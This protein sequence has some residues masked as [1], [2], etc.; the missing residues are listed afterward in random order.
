MIK[1]GEPEV[2]ELNTN[3]TKDVIKLNIE[4]K[5]DSNPF[6]NSSLKSKPTNSGGGLELLMNTKKQSS[7]NNNVDLKDLQELENDLNDLTNTK[8]NGK[9][10]NVSFGDSTKL[11]FDDLN[12]KSEPSIKIDNIGNEVNKLLAGDQIGRVVIQHGE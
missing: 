2:I 8:T 5:S 9:P 1:I 11:K 4:E 7:N 10:L 6:S 3:N 12:K